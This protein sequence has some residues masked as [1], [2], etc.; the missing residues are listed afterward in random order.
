V[1]KPCIITFSDLAHSFIVKVF[2]SFKWQGK[3]ETVIE[4]FVE[5]QRSLQADLQMHASLGISSANDSLATLDTKVDK[6]VE[7]MFTV[8]RSPEERE[9]T[10]FIANKGGPDAVLKS[11]FLLKDMLAKQ[12]TPKDDSASK[13]SQIAVTAKDIRTEVK[14]EVDQIV[15]N[16]KLFDQKFDEQRRQLEEVKTLVK[17]ESDRVIEAVLSGPHDRIVNRVRLV[18]FHSKSHTDGLVGHTS[19]LERDGE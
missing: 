10:D 11:D 2:T 12:R 9:M 18:S 8:M 7:M 3:F 14:M 15:T 16:N 6:L 17:R 1:S 4:Q 13:G 5:H 19:N